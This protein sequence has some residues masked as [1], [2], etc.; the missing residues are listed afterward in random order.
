M[1]CRIHDRGGFAAG[2]L[3]IGIAELLRNCHV[4][5]LRPQMSNWAVRSL[6]GV[7]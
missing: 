4:G 2:V 7:K 3:R 1:V 6:R 5:G